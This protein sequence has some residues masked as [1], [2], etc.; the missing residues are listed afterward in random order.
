MLYDEFEII[1]NLK[2]HK[3]ALGFYGDKRNK[4]IKN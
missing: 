1:Q 2:S 4:R 3:T